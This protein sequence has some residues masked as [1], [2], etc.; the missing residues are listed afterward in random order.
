MEPEGPTGSTHERWYGV[1]TEG[2][3]HDRWFEVETEDRIGRVEDK[4]RNTV[5]YVLS[6]GS[7]QVIA[8]Y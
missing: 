8:L 5:N 6:G 7:M 4:T 2:S 3:T 1:E